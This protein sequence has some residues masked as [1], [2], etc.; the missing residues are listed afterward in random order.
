MLIDTRVSQAH[1]AHKDT[2]V[3]ALTRILLKKREDEGC[4][5]NSIRVAA[6]PDGRGRGEGSARTL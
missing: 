1:T 3:D 6:V 2:L 4:D 5:D